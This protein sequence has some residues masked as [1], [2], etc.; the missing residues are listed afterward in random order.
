MMTGRGENRVIRPLSAGG[1]RVK[2]ND[3]LSRRDR[4]GGEHA[5][6]IRP[7]AIGQFTRGVG[8]GDIDIWNA[9]PLGN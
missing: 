8:N 1:F 2:L 6:S 7:A 4:L 9:A 5:L 3:I